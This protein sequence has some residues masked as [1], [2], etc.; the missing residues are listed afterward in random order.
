MYLAIMIAIF[1]LSP[2]GFFFIRMVLHL[3]FGAPRPRIIQKPRQSAAQQLTDYATQASTQI[4][5]MATYI[6][7]LEEMVQ[8][9]QHRLDILNAE[10]E[11]LK[12]HIRGMEGSADRAR[13]DWK[14][15]RAE[16]D[17]I[18]QAF[19]VLGLRSGASWEAV[20]AAFRARAKTC[21]PDHG[22]DPEA[23]KQLNEAYQRLRDTYGM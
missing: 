5:E 13:S 2:Y 15:A 22:G 7:E 14:T 16:P 12:E 8:S 9:T 6:L 11:A 20:K 1:G 3:G 17:G 4:D 23:F 19:Y 18:E 10:N 21:H